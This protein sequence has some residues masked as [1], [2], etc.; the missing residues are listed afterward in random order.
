MVW[1]ILGAETGGGQEGMEPRPAG[2]VAAGIGCREW[3]GV[4]VGRV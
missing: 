4:G 2:R 1:T 3:R